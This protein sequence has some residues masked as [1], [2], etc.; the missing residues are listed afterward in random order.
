[1]A[2]DEGLRINE[3]KTKFYDDD[4]KNKVLLFHGS[5]HGINGELSLKHSNPFSDFGAGFY[6]GESYTQASSWVCDVD[7]GSVYCFYLDTNKLKVV[8]FDVDLEWALAICI[9]RGYLKEKENHPLIKEIKNKINNADV[10]YA[11][12]ADNVMYLT[13]QEF[14]EGFINEE[15]CKHALSA[16]HLGMQYVIKNETTL[17]KLE[18][19]SRLYLCKKEKDIFKE[20]KA[21]EEKGGQDKVRAARI[22]YRNK[23]RYIDEIFN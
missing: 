6:L 23:G 15:Q 16:N 1:M 5:K 9:N 7:E 14:A 8:K 22:K 4:K 11:P 19:I 10:I 21:E 2:I 13:I 12:I 17:N 18:P 3:I 20:L